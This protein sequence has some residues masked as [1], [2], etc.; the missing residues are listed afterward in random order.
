[1]Q[2]RD[3]PKDNKF[4]VAFSYAGEERQLVRS[5]A[6]AVER[7]LGPSNVFL[8]EWYE[9]YIGGDGGDLTLQKIYRERSALTILCVSKRYGEKPW[10]LAEHDA[11]RERVNKSRSSDNEDDR[12][13]VLPIRVGAGEVEGI[14]FNTIV[15][16][17][18]AK[19]PEETAEMIVAR[20]RL[21]IPESHLAMAAPVQPTWPDEPVYYDPGLANRTGQWPAIQ[22]LMTATSPKRIL[23]FEGPSMHSKTALLLVAQ[24]YAK[25]LHVPTS[26]VDFKDTQLLNQTNFF[27]QLQL[28]LESVLPR[29]AAAEEPNSWTLIKDLRR[30]VT[31]ALILLDTFEKVAETKD[32]VEWIEN[33]LFAEI[34]QCSQIRFLIGGQKTP[35]IINTRWQSFADKIEMDRINDKQVWKEWIQQQNPHVDDKHVES[36]VLGL[37]GVPGNISSVLTTFAKKLPGTPNS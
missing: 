16:D 9:Y 29:F 28:D 22:R 30:M 1:M 4:R 5:I 7:R 2:H 37:D 32:F 33:Q 23:I 15:P 10:T 13:G 8:D 35:N 14:S 27:R 26:F 36:I 19:T 12:L 34:E 11:I 3:L 25:I 6:E 18:R 21:I 20:L 17:V 31:P 24:R